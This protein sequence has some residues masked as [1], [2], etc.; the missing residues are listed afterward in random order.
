[1]L[2]LDIEPITAALYTVRKGAVVLRTLVPVADVVH[3]EIAWHR[4]VSLE[5]K[6]CFHLLGKN[7][8]LNVNTLL[9]ACDL[10]CRIGL[11]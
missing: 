6:L 4:A 3:D 8:V 7:A 11:A 10:S 9:D 2:F 5:Q 1:M